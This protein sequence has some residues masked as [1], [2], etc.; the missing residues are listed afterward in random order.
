MMNTGLAPRNPA[1]L[2]TGSSLKCPIVFY[3]KERK[4]R[5]CLLE[6]RYGEVEAGNILPPEV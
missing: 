2:I 5:I 1:P 4:P 6:V 3:K